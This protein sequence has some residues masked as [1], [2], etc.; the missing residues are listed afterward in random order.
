MK[1]Q[2]EAIAFGFLLKLM[3]SVMPQFSQIFLIIQVN[4]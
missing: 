1:H 3:I 4:K 2:T